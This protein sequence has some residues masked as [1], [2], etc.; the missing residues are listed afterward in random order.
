M[1]AEPPA[2][3][4]PRAPAEPEAPA[5]PRAPGAPALPAG[6][7]LRPVRD[8][9]REL[10]Y[11]IYASTRAD[12]LAT[13]DW[14]EEQKAWFLRHQFEA[15]DHHYRQYYAD[16]ELSI[17][18]Q[19]GVPVGRLYVARWQK[20]IRLV[21]IALLPEHRGSGLGRAL[22]ER[23]L[24]EGAAAHKP[25]SIHVEVYNP[26]MRLYQRLGFEPTGEERGPY[27]LMRWTPP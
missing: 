11:R 21:D 19:D 22:V 8:D 18:E 25:V 23:L 27:K 4:E 13:V 5:E 26:A 12:E 2:P 20:E 3:A 10:L 6:I 1:P 7:T 14:A 24:A 9:D 15:Q 17:V 16:A